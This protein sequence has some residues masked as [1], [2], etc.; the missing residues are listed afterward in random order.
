M[1]ASS[2]RKTP[3]FFAAA[4]GKKLQLKMNFCSEFQAKIVSPP[5]LPHSLARPGGMG[6][7]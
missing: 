5:A 2:A 7:A 4:A 3:L 1:G 6:H